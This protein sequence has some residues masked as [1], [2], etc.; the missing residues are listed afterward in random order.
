MVQM[1]SFQCNAQ[2]APVKFFKLSL[3]LLQ[4]VFITKADISSINKY[5]VRVV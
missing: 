5:T 1:K 2:L 3:H 4:V